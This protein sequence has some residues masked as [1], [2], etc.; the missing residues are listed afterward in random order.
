MSQFNFDNVPTE[1]QQLSVELFNKMQQQCP[2]V[3]LKID[4]NGL[5]FHLPP[6][7]YE[8]S[9][10]ETMETI[11][12]TSQNIPSENEQKI[13]NGI[14]D[15]MIHTSLSETPPTYAS[16]AI[17]LTIYN[18][19]MELN[20]FSKVSIQFEMGRILK[21]LTVGTTKK[22]RIT[23]AQQY[24]QRHVTS[25]NVQL[26]TKTAMRIHDY[27]ENFSGAL[28]YKALDQYFKPHAIG[29][30]TNASSDHLK[31]CIQEAFNNLILPA[32]NLS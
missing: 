13:I 4:I 11:T 25:Q 18:D 14:L 32:L 26:K 1:I 15:A 22:R 19:L 27:F 17:S 30:L 8:E 31:A 12:T 20:Q 6:P 24:M 3:Q 21:D 10:A 29:R 2:N 9:I 5:Q 23:I 16:T 28:N 7:F